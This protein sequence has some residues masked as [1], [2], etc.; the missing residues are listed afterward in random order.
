MGKFGGGVVH[1]LRECHPGD[2][3]PPP[4]LLFFRTAALDQG[5]LLGSGLALQ[6][7]PG[8]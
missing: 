3:I 2:V 7:I 1:G 8:S 6:S 4:Y 5:V